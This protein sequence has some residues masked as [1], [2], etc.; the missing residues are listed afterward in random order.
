MSLGL[1]FEYLGRSSNPMEKSPVS[2]QED[3]FE[4]GTAPSGSTVV[5]VV[6]GMVLTTEAVKIRLVTFGL[7]PELV[8]VLFEYGA[9]GN[10]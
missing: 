9:P 4:E 3:G 10:V 2:P 5:I 8:V 6:T 7:L 1:L